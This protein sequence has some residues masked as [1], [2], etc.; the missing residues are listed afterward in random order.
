MPSLIDPGADVSRAVHQLD[1]IRFATSQK[2]YS[3]L[4]YEFDPS[5]IQD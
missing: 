5:Q 4:V 1:A 2:L 3:A